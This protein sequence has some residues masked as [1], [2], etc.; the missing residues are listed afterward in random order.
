MQ[1]RGAC[2]GVGPQPLRRA[3]LGLQSCGRSPSSQASRPRR[4]V[5]VR[6]AGGVCGRGRAG[7]RHRARRRVIGQA[8]GVAGLVQELGP[9]PQASHA[10]P[11]QRVQHRRLQWRHAT[12]WQELWQEHP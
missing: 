11:Q 6:R 8:G 9:L 10:R 4:R 2:G 1:R 7:L 3:P 12:Q 5:G